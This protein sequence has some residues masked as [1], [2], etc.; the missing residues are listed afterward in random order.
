MALANDWREAP[1]A[2]TRVPGHCRVGDRPAGSEVV[3]GRR[4]ASALHRRA[5]HPQLRRVRRHWRARL[6]HRRL[7]TRSCGGFPPGALPTGRSPRTSRASLPAPGPAA[8]TSA[9][10][11]ASAASISSPTRCSG[12]KELEGGCDRMAISPDGATLYVPSLEGPHWHVV[13]ARDGDVVT[14]IVTD[15][16]RTTPSTRSTAAMPISPGCARRC[17][18]LPTPARTQW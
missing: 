17:C 7:R 9:P 12:S 14:K 15:R 10:S 11:S 6:R 13:N 2:Q 18:R 3:R 1:D 5:R 8:S 4:A 16:A